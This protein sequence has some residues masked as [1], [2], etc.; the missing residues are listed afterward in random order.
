MRAVLDSSVLTSAFLNPNGT[1]AQLLARAQQ[2]AFSLYVSEYIIGE[3][4]HALLRPRIRES[5]GHTVEEVERFLD[6]L[7]RV[8]DIIYDVPSI[9][10]TSRDQNDDSIIACALKAQAT[11]LV[12]GDNDLLSLGSHAGVE[13]VTP[14]HFFDL[15]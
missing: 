3:T 7:I 2:G 8:A 1:P 6:L 15:L 14:R 12:T 4:T 5:Y 10:P 11:Y 13:M 9:A